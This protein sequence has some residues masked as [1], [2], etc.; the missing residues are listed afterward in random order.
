MVRERIGR[1]R[2]MEVYVSTP[3][4]TCETR[5]PKGLYKKARAGLLPN[6]TGVGSAYEAPAHPDLAIDTSVV[7]VS[8][9]VNTLV[10]ALHE[11]RR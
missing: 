1:E 3:L 5:D 4:E 10:M 9:A 7:P 2:F 11:L 6:L 8:A